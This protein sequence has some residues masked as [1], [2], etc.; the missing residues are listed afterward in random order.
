MYLHIINKKCS[1]FYLKL[2]G[3]DNNYYY[4]ALNSSSPEHPEYKLLE[5]L[6]VKPYYAEFTPYGY[7]DYDYKIPKDKLFE[8]SKECQTLAFCEI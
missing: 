5:E 3:E 7:H 1:E 2:N 6:G 4:L 8:M